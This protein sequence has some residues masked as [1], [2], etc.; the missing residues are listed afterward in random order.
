MFDPVGVFYMDKLICAAIGLGVVD[1]RRPVV[2]N[3]TPLAAASG[4]QVSELV[5][6][7]LAKPR[8]VGLIAEIRATG[9]TVTLLGE[10]DISA[11]GRAASGALDLV[12]GIGGT[13]EGIIAA[14][15]VRVL[16]GFMQG[17]LAPQSREQNILALAS[18]HDLEHV[19]ELDELVASDS[20][21]FV[22]SE[23]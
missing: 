10:G 1:I 9:A 18:G 23:V 4:K 5:V 22:S 16:G 7:V 20:V 6:A 12:L 15:A 8:H 17:R 2:D 13:P 3:L 11:A 19:F 21:L 14:C